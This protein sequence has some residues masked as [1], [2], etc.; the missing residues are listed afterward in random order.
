MKKILVAE[1]NDSN[2]LL[3]TYVLKGHYE[4]VRA[5]NGLEAARM[6]NNDESIDLVLMDLR[7]PV[8]D[9][10]QATKVIK[11]KRPHLPV[12]AIT[13]NAFDADRE[14]ALAAGCDD[15][16]SKPVAYQACLELLAK[17]LEG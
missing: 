4:Y 14:R 3:M 12:I 13:A 16:L 5:E 9:G 6:V 10:L 15:F 2:F 7:M 8:M 1:D 11:Q 17:Y